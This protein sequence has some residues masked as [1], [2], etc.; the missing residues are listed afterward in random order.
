M[1]VFIKEKTEHCIKDDYVRP[2]TTD[3]N[4]TKKAIDDEQRFLS[5]LFLSISPELLTIVMNKNTPLEA[6]NCLQQTFVSN[7]LDEQIITKSQFDSLKLGNL[8]M[9]DYISKKMSL[10]H[11]LTL[12]GVTTDDKQIAASIYHGLKESPYRMYVKVL[13][14]ILA[15]HYKVLLVA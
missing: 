4:E 5:T 3:E 9:S 6:W 15:V 2:S 13:K 10:A 14:K 7:T 12:T 1:L 8:T 11:Q